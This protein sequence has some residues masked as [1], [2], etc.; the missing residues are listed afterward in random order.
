MTDAPA[1]IFVIDAIQNALSSPI[2]FFA[3][4]SA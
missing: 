3:S 2:S 4:T 1:N